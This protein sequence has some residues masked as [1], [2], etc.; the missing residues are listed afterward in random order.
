MPQNTLSGLN[1]RTAFKAT[2]TQS[3]GVPE[4]ANACTPS[5]GKSTGQTSI[6][7]QNVAE[8]DIALCCLHG[9]TTHTS[10]NLT[11]VS[12]SLLIPSE[13]IPSS[14]VISIFLIRNLSKH[15]TGL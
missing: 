4:V 11:A 1:G 14:F 15:S 5:T 9:A 8:W 13:S 6:G 7:V 2:Q 10:P 3:D 12:A